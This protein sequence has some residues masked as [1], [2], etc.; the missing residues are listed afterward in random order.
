MTQAERLIRNLCEERR[1]ELVE[2]QKAALAQVP[3]RQEWRKLPP[4]VQGLVIE[5]TQLEARQAA[6][7]KRLKA[8][9][10]VT[11]YNIQRK[12]SLQLRD[13]DSKQQQVRGR[14]SSRFEEVQRLKTTATIA[15]LGKTAQ[16]AQGILQKLQK[17]LKRV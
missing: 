8:M 16:E 4:K 13:H 14:Y 17:D 3:E 15:S 5:F 9:G 1:L 7:R 10:Y 6:I 2:S 12:T 11:H